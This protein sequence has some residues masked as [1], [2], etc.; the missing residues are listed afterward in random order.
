MRVVVLVLVSVF[1][2]FIRCLSL[3]VPRRSMVEVVLAIL[4]LE[5]FASIRTFCSSS[6]GEGPDL[7]LISSAF[8]PV[9]P[10]L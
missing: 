3:G 9:L 8:N 4:L 7:F 2:A 5:G 10:V 1:I 6:F